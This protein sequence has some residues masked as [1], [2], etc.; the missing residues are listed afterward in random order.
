MAITRSYSHLVGRHVTSKAVQV[1]IDSETA[2][3]KE[4]LKRLNEFKTKYE[5]EEAAGLRGSI[6]HV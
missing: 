6:N 4:H 5:A 1:E 3:F 2:N